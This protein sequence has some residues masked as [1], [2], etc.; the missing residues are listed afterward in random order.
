M[1]KL[2]ILFFLILSETLIAQNV[3]IG[4]V[5][6]GSKLHVVS[7]SSGYAG[8][9]FPGITVEG[10]AHT[11][12][13]L[14]VPNSN[15]TGV[16]FG[17]G[18]DATSG[19]I[20]YNNAGTLNGLQFRTNGNSTKMVLDQ[21]GLVGI[22]NNNPTFPLSFSGSFGNKISLW[23]TGPAH[24]DWV[25]KADY[26]GICKTD[27]D[28]IAFGYGSSTNFS[29]RGRI[30]NSGANGMEL[31]GR[32]L[33]KRNSDLNNGGGIWLYK[34]DNSG[35]LGFM[36]TQNNQNIGFYGGPAGWGFIYDA[37]NSRVG[38]GNNNP[39]AP[40]SFPAALGKKITL[41]PGASG[42]VGMAVQGNLFQIYAD[43]SN[44]D[45]A[46]GY[47][48]SGTMTERMRIKANGSVGIGTTTPTAL[49]EVNGYTK[50]GSDAPSIKVK[51]LTGTTAATEGGFVFITHGLNSLKILAVSILVQ[52]GGVSYGPNLQGYSVNFLWVTNS[53]NVRS[54]MFSVTP[55]LF[56]QN[57]LEY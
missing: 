12:F 49:L 3:G 15:E 18:S 7:G 56:C 43:N 8:G 53:G 5:N 37:L 27:L 55:P 20:V 21:N 6:P 31:N 11:Y 2:A 16:L 1:Q 24:F 41:Y 40:L 47:D 46:F 26:S 44:A 13:N 4:T 38:I 39:N 10:N 34:A 9:N 14:L 57:P 52:N 36:G 30:I 19:G 17:K 28:N 22:G 50:L 32:I 54:L 51:K 33:K 25:F 35:L 29:E 42:D 48:Q 23:M 45:I